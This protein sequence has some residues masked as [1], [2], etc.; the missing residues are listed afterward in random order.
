MP[1]ALVV[2]C[3]GMVGNAHAV[4][5]FSNG[6]FTSNLDDWATVNNVTHVSEYARLHGGET[7]GV[8]EV[9]QN[10]AALEDGSAFEAGRAYT[11]SFS[12]YGAGWSFVSI[13]GGTGGEQR[14]TLTGA[15]DTD[16][17]TDSETYSFGVDGAT[18]WTPYAYT[19][20]AQTGSQWNVFFKSYG[21]MG[22]DNVRI[23]P[24][25]IPEPETYALMLM[26]LAMLGL[27]KRHQRRD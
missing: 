8:A 27:L 19:F 10:F 14:P 16:T 11:V 26:G 1:A 15:G 4:D 22:L 25:V 13:A 3:A 17:D 12:A 7:G 18:M 9:Y 20:T 24:S 5:S 21:V 6:E 2:A 23:S